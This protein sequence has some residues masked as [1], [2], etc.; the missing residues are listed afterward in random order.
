MDEGEGFR[1]YA[2]LET[3]WKEELSG[4]LMKADIPDVYT[5]LST[6]FS[7]A[8][9]SANSSMTT[10]PAIRWY[11]KR[12]IGSINWVKSLAAN[13]TMMLS[14]GDMYDAKYAM[15]DLYEIRG[16]SHDDKCTF[17]QF[18]AWFWNRDRTHP[19][20]SPR[21]GGETLLL[22][23]DMG[24]WAE[25]FAPEHCDFIKRFVE[26]FR[27]K[28]IDVATIRAMRLVSDKIDRSTLV[29]NPHRDGR[30]SHLT[31]NHIHSLLD[32]IEHLGRSD[33]S[34]HL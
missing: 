2:H 10:L 3:R 11:M 15:R 23:V 25:T 24:I 22:L 17:T 7:N 4:A 29:R 8:E 6:L 31:V 12:K 26:D 21:S 13:L 9:F 20:T 1:A 28:T 16:H 27:A 5:L 34:F 19:Y 18:N 30:R 14:L 32:N 33:I